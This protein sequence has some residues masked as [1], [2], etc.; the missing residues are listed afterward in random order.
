VDT[1]LKSISSLVEKLTAGAEE[2]GDGGV[3]LIEALALKER[4]VVSLVGSGGKTTLMFRLAKDLLRKGRNVVT[5]TTTK[6]LEP[7]REESST[8]CVDSDEARLKEFVCDRIGRDHHITIAGERIGMGKLKGIS[9][10]LVTELSAL[11]RIDYILVEADGA[12]GRPVKAPRE[13]E[14]VI[15]SCTTLVVAIAGMDGIGAELTEENAFQPERISRLTGIPMGGRLTD[16]AMVVLMTHPEGVWKGTPPS[17]RVIAF[18]NKVDVPGGVIHGRKVAQGI[19]KRRG[20]SIDRVVLGQLK[21]A[22][23]VVE[24]LIAVHAGSGPG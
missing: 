7:S 24:V 19:L 3:T 1:D 4:E 14:P 6:I 15:P 9:P 18:L 12:S 11:P 22:P 21:K 23:P 10:D 8:L 16:E 17:S 5:T 20:D 13:K 2:K